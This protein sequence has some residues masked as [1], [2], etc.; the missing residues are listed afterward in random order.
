MTV[1]YIDIATYGLIEWSVTKEYAA[2]A[3]STEWPAGAALPWMVR[4]TYGLKKISISVMAEGTTREGIWDKCS[5]LV[6]ILLKPARITLNEF[7]GRYFYGVVT[8]A[9]QAETALR[10]WHKATLDIQCYEYGDEVVTTGTGTYI[11]VNN[12]GTMPTPCSIE[13]GAATAKDEMHIWGLTKKPSGTDVEIT[14][15]GLIAD[16]ATYSNAVKIDGETGLISQGT[17]GVMTN[18]WSRVTT[19]YALPMLQPGNNIV[20]FEGRASMS[21]VTATVKY[22]PMY[23]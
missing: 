15:T 6:G 1:N 2:I 11:T 21:D 17:G 18:P 8:N 13:V 9:A 3:N 20:S 23:I 22:K 7:P 4:G 14:I 16:A 19:L 10:R 5:K 12:I